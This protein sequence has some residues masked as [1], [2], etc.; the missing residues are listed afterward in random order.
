MRLR[1]TTIAVALAAAVTVP[2]VVAVAESAAASSVTSVSAAHSAKPGKT[3]KATKKTKFT[4][5]G[6]VTAVTGETVTVKVKGGTKDV[7]G[8]TVAVTVPSSAQVLVNGVRKVAADL[9]VGDAVTITGT[10]SGGALT[11]ARVQARRVKVRPAPTVSPAPSP[12]ASPGDDD[13]SDDDGPTAEP[14]ETPHG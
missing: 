8:R 6:V 4:A 13:S 11:A 10:S 5:S 9:L 3:P 1:R 7:R 2:G 12:T 14:S